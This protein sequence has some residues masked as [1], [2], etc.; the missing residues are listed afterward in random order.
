M[1]VQ[2]VFN[3][4][5]IGELSD[6]VTQCLLDLTDLSI[7]MDSQRSVVGEMMF[8]HQMTLASSRISAYNELENNLLKAV[9][10]RDENAVR[11]LVRQSDALHAH[12]DGKMH[13]T[14]ILWK[15]VIIAPRHLADIILASPTIP[16]DYQFVDD[17]NGR[18]CLHEAATRGEARLVDLCI[19]KG[20]QVDRADVYGKL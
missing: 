5:L 12:A 15:V 19:S 9:E 4:Q 6:I 18:T 11:E 10:A 16:F 8:D 14:R 17:I 7:G 2:P 20:V 13:V 1:E 3:R